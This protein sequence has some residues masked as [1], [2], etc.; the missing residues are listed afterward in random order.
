MSNAT[1]AYANTI[2]K[3][4]TGGSSG[5][6]FAIGSLISQKLN[7]ENLKSPDNSELVFLNQRSSGSVANV[8]DLDN[9]MINGGLVQAD[10]LD[11]AFH[12]K[13][14]FQGLKHA[15]DLRVVGTL[16]H[17]SVHLVVRAS[18]DINNITDL[19]GKRVAVDELGSGTQIDVD[20][21]LLA[22]EMTRDDIQAVFVKPQNAM[23]RMR[24]EMLDAFF[25]VAG[26]PVSGVKELVDEGIGRVVSFNRENLQQAVDQLGFFKVGVIPE[27]TYS[28]DDSILTLSVPA[29]LVVRADQDDDIVYQ[30]TKHLW[31]NEMLDSLAKG[32]PR[33]RDIDPNTAL[34]GVR[35]P[36]HAGALRFYQERG[37]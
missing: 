11:L 8:Y 2:F 17:E 30:V 19:A 12:S 32:H 21:I 6:Y 1:S 36:V 28:N 14:P 29:Q 26:Y 33:G 27:S 10:V 18:S 3:L 34:Q 20:L 23:D 24:R 15:K 16:Y 5:A 25:V 22:H 7:Q 4:G 31:S 35:I 37:L 9:Q 13:S